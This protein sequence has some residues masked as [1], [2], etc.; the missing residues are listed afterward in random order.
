M[1]NNEKLATSWKINLA[2]SRIGSWST[3]FIHCFSIH[4][5]LRIKLIH[6]DAKLMS[7]L[8]TQ[9]P[10]FSA[11]AFCRGGVGSRM[12]IYICFL[13]VIFHLKNR[14]PPDYLEILICQKLLRKNLIKIVI[15][16]LL[17]FCLIFPN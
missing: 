10:D 13:M 4:D 16:L 7:C 12:T 11:E 17:V 6:V 2:T 15:L 14:I 3:L 5:Y 9:L 1:K 8:V